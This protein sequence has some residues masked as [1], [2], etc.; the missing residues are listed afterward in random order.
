M[1]TLNQ[2]SVTHTHDTSFI[3]ATHNNSSDFSILNY[4]IL[5][6]II[7]GKLHLDFSVSETK[8]QVF[9]PVV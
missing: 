6:L 7:A 5:T 2:V 3:C 4:L 8:L 1:N 9:T